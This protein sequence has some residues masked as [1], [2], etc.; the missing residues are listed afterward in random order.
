MKLSLLA[1]A[2]LLAL[3]SAG[4]ASAGEVEINDAVARVVVIPE[5]RSDIDVS[6]TQGSAELPAITVRRRGDDVIVDGHLDRRIRTCRGGE[7]FVGDPTQMPRGV[8]VEVR[9]HGT[10]DMADAPL[11]IVRTPMNVEV[12]SDGA[13][14]GAVGRA[15][16]V[17]LGAGG[18]GDWSVGNTE[19]ALSVAVGGSGDVRTGTARTLEV[20]VGGSG[21]VRTGAVTSADLAIGGSGD[22]RI[23]SVSGPVEVA[24]GGSGNVTID[25]GSAPRLEVAIAGSGEVSF[26]GEAGDVD[27]TIAGSG[28]I[29][30]QRVTGRVERA[31]LGSGD[32][33]IG[34]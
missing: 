21:D 32:I 14:W 2:G 15:S 34:S 31:I 4:A 26:A 23:A 11:I 25:G 33:R 29:R 5:N 10:I 9:G 7:E 12:D 13:V 20:A 16:S 22:I 19:G 30:V 24:I 6:V 17:E 1:G 27:A 28:D 18:C 8:T 3:V